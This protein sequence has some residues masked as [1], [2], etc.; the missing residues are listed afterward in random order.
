MARDRWI[1]DVEPALADHR[2]DGQTLLPGAAFIEMGLAVARDWEG[3]DAVALGGFEIQQPLDF[4]PNASREILCRV[5]SSTA[6]VEILSRPRLAKTAFALHARGTV[7]QQ[8]GPVAVGLA[9]GG[10]RAGGRGRAKRFTCARRAS[11]LDFGPAFRRLAKAERVGVD[12][13]EVELTSR[14]R[15]TRAMGSI[16]RASIP[17]STGL[18]CCSRT[19][20]PR[21]APICRC[22]STR[23]ACSGPARR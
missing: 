17:V 13:I 7:L 16:P 11:G 22:D 5:E 4:P 18:S 20:T 21:P 9:A 8:P 3:A 19:S 6:T 14:S 12:A 10:P 1:R 23:C 2:V 15:P